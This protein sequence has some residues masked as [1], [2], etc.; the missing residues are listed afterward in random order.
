MEIALLVV[1][2]LAVAG[3]VAYVQH[4]RRQARVAAA[5]AL[6]RRIGFSF[7]LRDDDRLVDLPFSLFGRGDGRAVELVLSG[8]HGGRPLRMF[9]YWYYDRSTDS[10]GRT[11]R[12]YHRYS[13]GLLTIAA[14]CSHLRLAHENFLTRLGQHVGVRDVEFESD[15]F[16]QRFRVACD[17]QR[18]AFC[19]VDGRMME[20]LLGAPEFDTLELV[21]PWVLLAAPRRD[22]ARWPELGTWLD[23]F[24]AHVPDIVYAEYG[25]R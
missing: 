1:A 24:V 17:D 13:C 11:S 21:G 25:P 15:D 14:A 10:K 22:P 16:N 5:Q 18:F 20:W 2:G 7:A 19:L 9:D 3:A 12:T 8:T 6:G 4:R 23:E